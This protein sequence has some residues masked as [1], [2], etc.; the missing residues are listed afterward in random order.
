MNE[1]T[2]PAAN[3]AGITGVGLISCYVDD[4][5]KVLPF[6][7]ETLGLTDWNPMGPQAGAFTVSDDTT[8]FVIGGKSPSSL[9][10]NSIRCTFAFRVDSVA[11]FTD[12]LTQAGADL[13]LEAPMQ[14]NEET[15]WIQFRDPSGNLLEAI[16]GK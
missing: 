15:W 12:R 3:V 2:M 16:G 9:D 11:A 7:T 5:Q 10:R 8:L 13:M 6:Y 4:F 1:E 14:M